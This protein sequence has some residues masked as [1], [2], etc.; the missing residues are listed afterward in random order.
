MNNQIDSV[1]MNDYLTQLPIDFRREIKLWKQDVQRKKVLKKKLLDLKTL[2]DS[3]NQVNSPGSRSRS[4]SRSA[5][6][7]DSDKSIGSFN[8][9]VLS[10]SQ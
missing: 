4:G 3:I 2:K 1:R 5:E 7:S 9:S 6:P 8:R 10:Y